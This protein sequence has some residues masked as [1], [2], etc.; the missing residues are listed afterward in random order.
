[1]IEAHGTGT[2]LGDPI[3]AGALLATY[4]SE[5]LDGDP[6]LLG[7][8]KSN[9]GHPQAAAG[10]A[11]V[12]K[13]VLAMRAG[14]LPKT[15]HVDRPSSK[16]EWPTGRVELLTEPRPWPSGDRPRR[17]AVSSFGASG[18]N[19]HLILEEPPEPAAQ[20]DDAAAPVFDDDASAPRQEPP[21]PV[22][23]LPLSAKSEGALAQVAANLATHLREYPELD[24]TDVS[25]SLAT[26]RA[27]FARRA[28]A[29]G[30]SREELLDSLERLAAGQEGPGAVR[31]LARNEQRPVFLFSGQ[32][33]QHAQMALDLIDGSSTFATSIEEC[34]EALAPFVDWSL[35]EVLREEQG[36]WLD[37]LDVVQPALFAVMVSLAKLWRRCGV[38]PAA[39]A[40][41][42]QG[43][44]AAAHIAGGLSLS[45]AARVIALRAKAMTKIAGKGGML[46]VSL[47]PKKLEPRLSPYEGRVSLAAINGPASL[48]LS[49]EPEALAELKDAFEQDGVRAQ[50][51]AVDY[52][53]HSAQIEELRSELL[54]AFA[55]INPQSGEVPFH[56]TVT[57][58]EAIDTAELGPTY[59]YRNLRQTVQMEPLLRS[60]L[61]GGQ[62]NFLEIGPHPVLAFG[63]QETIDQVLGQ[64]EKANVL[65]TLRRE[66]GGPERFALSLA[67][68]HASGVPIDWSTFF[69]GSAAK[70]VP[71]PTYP[72]QRQRF[73]L[74]S[75]GNGGDPASI[76]QSDPSHPLLGAKV[77]DPESGGFSLTGRISLPTHP[78]LADHAVAGTVLLPGTAFVEL[79]L[80][81]AREAGAESVAELTLQ[82]PL[83]VPEQ[84]AIALQVSVSPAETEQGQEI[85]IHSRPQGEE[86]A[87]WTLH[88]QGLLSS[89][90]PEAPAPLKQWPPQ[91]A[92]AIET[93]GLYEELA[94][95]GFEYGPAFQGLQAAWR[96]GEDLYAEVTLA[97][98]Q[99][100]EA[101]AYAIHPAL[102]DSAGHAALQQI[103][104]GASEDGKAGPA[105]PF[106]WHG[107]RVHASGA[108][109]LRV[110]L[111]AEGEPGLSAFDQSGAPVLSVASLDVREVDP[112]V[113][114]AAAAQ[115]LPLHRVQWLPA[116][117]SPPEQPTTAILG[118][119]D[120]GLAG[121]EVYADLAAL[122]EA[123]AEGAQAPELILAP[124][125]A[126]GELPAAAHQ[127][128]ERSLA[129]AQELLANE[130]LANTRL[131]LLTT[132][133][134]AAAEGE[135][136]DLATAALWGLLRSAHS[137]H[138]G[139]FCLID[140][141]GSEASTEA[142]SQA[143]AQSEAEPQLA[144][145]EG[146]ALAPRLERVQEIP[147][148]AFELDPERTVLITGA[149]SG[150]GA[151]VA[152]HLTE[153]HGARHLLLVS[154]S[155]EKAEGAAELRE[156]LEELGAS[157]T[158]AACDVAE[159]DQLEV[160]FASIPDKHPLGAIVH[161]AGVLDDGV[162]DSLDPERLDRVMRPKVDAAWHL[163]ELSEAMELSAFVLFSSA[164]GILGA[165]GQA[166]YAAANSFLDALAAHRRSQG[167]AAHSLA[168]G[169]WG[170][171]TSLLDAEITAEA[172]R[173]F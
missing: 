104:A 151:L 5:R 117:S 103:A 74:T 23:L 105:L 14:L 99:Q 100:S 65:P 49:G 173:F 67:Q 86:G 12:I 128:A 85:R 123:I 121:A 131:C 142:L 33:A 84:G 39:V 30:K 80:A 114:Q 8:I 107:V 94:E 102:L 155:G 109:T 92:Q 145:R 166:N 143:L 108:S 106:A 62:R 58:K 24:P 36:S 168:W 73:W 171:K 27:S 53:A 137:E 16:I 42:S 29:V 132:K 101:G 111:A 170:Q 52:A 9:I 7:T 167:R 54:E 22:T 63:V 35:T 113:L 110:R 135:Q 2:A 45:D 150:I 3:E 88:A 119:L 13:M 55:P 64:E 125:E 82:S 40:G 120:V 76:G 17:A 91:G 147:E 1:M 134:I 59:W 4:G 169:G 47:S 66:E 60:L 124:V 71:L 51:I 77:E 148:Q 69:Q 115:S 25:Y 41:H 136:P 98:E 126:E 158:I 61:E 18:T 79:A 161:S 122:S 95:I 43:E 149:T 112:N 157:A 116:E 34:E 172:E 32:G 96:E 140:S 56:S 133:A 87:Q 72:F 10:V 93:A 160:L 159:R 152:R 44:I 21:L 11:G 19:A 75:Q 38:S 139:R 48:V 26:S 165:P 163:H 156:G 129:L 144:L 118:A 154:R 70:R 83:I 162:L 37:R 146:R 164:A 138:P 20:K 57:G 78:W 28:V 31:S 97:P 6:L 90:S 50:T 68:A 141:D 46:S 15:L 153:A 130:E 127:S 89:E 81:A